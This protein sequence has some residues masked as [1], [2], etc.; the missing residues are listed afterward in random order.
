MLQLVGHGEALPSLGFAAID[1]DAPGAVFPFVAQHLQARQAGDQGLWYRWPFEAL[2]GEQTVGLQLSDA[3][4]LV[5]FESPP[6][7][8]SAQVS[9]LASAE[10]ASP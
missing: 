9:Q 6:R 1:A 10:A 8:K 2:G 3:Q 4:R 7:D 5:V